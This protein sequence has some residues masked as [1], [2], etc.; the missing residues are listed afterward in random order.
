[1]QSNEIYFTPQE[2]EVT[3]NITFLKVK[4]EAI[5]KVMNFFSQYRYAL[6]QLM[7]ENQWYSMIPCKPGDVKIAKG[8][9]YRELPYVVMDY[10][11]KFTFSDI[12]AY[13]SMFWWGHFFSFTL[14]LQGKSL[15]K[16]RSAFEQSLEPRR[17]KEIYICVNEHP[18]DYHYGKDNYKKLNEFQN[19]E[20]SI[21][22]RN[23]DFLKL[24]AQIPLQRNLDKI[25]EKGVQTFSQLMQWLTNPQSYSSTIQ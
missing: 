2:F 1:M 23:K 17:S 5:D 21:L 15:R 9:N 10:P 11:R 20:L 14:H 25:E 4:R 8:D 16:F 3:R 22:I 24:S 6:D 13:R 19:N 7:K 12:F 18:W